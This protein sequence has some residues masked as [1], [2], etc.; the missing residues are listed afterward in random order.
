MRLMKLHYGLRISAEMIELL[1][2]L[3]RI[4]QVGICLPTTDK[5]YARAMRLLKHGFATRGADHV[6]RI[7][8]LGRR[9]M[10]VK[11]WIYQAGRSGQADA[12]PAP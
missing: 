12:S 2:R 9:A 7:T 1:K 5:Q 3:D 11:P 8:A 10:K 4:G 6:Y